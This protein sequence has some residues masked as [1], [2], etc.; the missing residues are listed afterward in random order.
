LEVMGSK[1]LK[2]VSGI[3]LEMSRRQASP[4][5]PYLIL[6]EGAKRIGSDRAGAESV[7]VAKG[8]ANFMK[9]AL[10]P[11]GVSK[12]LITELKD[13]VVTKD[14]A[15]MLES[16]S[17]SHPVAWIIQD[18]VKNLEKSVGD[19]S[20]TAVIVIGELAKRLASLVNPRKRGQICMLVS[21]CR[22]AY[23][24]ALRR[25]RKLAK[26]FRF[27]DH[28]VMRKLAKTMLSSRGIEVALDY[29]S[30]L[31]VK[32][33]LK[34][35]QIDDHGARLNP[36][37]VQIVKKNVGSLSES[38]LIL[39]AVID[40]SSDRGIMHLLMPKSVRNVKVALINTAIKPTDKFK[41]MRIYKREIVFRTA[42][43]L[44]D[45]LEEHEKIA[46]EM[47][48]KIISVGAGAVFSKRPIHM[49]AAY[50]LAKAGIPAV[51]RLI[52][53][54]K[55]ELVAKA[56]G[57]RPVTRLRDLSEEDLGWAELVEER[58]I[59]RDQVIVIEGGERSRVV[60]ILLKSS[61]EKLLD[62]V[63]RALRNVITA[64]AALS[65]DPAYVP[66][67]GA[68]EEAVS[69]FLTKEAEKQPTWRQMS[70]YA[71][72]ST[73]E[74]ISIML[75]MNSGMD[76]V[77]ALTELR[78]KHA[79]GR[80]EYGVDANS[81]QIADMYKL[82]VIEPLAVKEQVLKM[83]YETAATIL[84]IGEIIDRRESKKYLEDRLKE[85]K[86]KKHEIRIP[87]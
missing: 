74:Q 75:A 69:F 7:M 79:E 65:K 9:P 4:D 49:A 25:L 84:R 10:G 40:R 18:A 2:W 45:T 30:D 44:K 13:I 38:E 17:F 37:D 8:L 77:N 59:G 19:G 72:A 70:M 21:E 54:K 16:M 73:L 34:V 41:R 57:A 28:D 85:L 50:E 81:R 31:V 55:V 11:K 61:S 6:R 53:T 76:P 52:S 63:E 1:V 14:G 62:E 12:L 78:S 46:V 47:A 5:T 24:L 39:G 15:R 67:G 48:K 22:A 86:E 51:E 33:V 29:L 42:E 71:F 58:R 36:D 56:T 26:P 87:D 68:A 82:G 60:T 80:H 32:A 27:G 3:T 20:K 23:D 64:F 35:S 83:A 43:L 66:G